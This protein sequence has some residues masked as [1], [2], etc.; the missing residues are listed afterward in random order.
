MN[1]QTVGTQQF[2][3]F[4][5]GAALFIIVPVVI[6]VI[7]KIRKKERFTS[8]LVGAA[9]FFLFAIILEKP[10]QNVLVFPT[11]MGL[12]D[13]SISRFINARPVLWALIIAL[14]PG[15]FEET[16]RFV[17]YKTVLKKYRN[18]ETSISYGIGHGGFEVMFILGMTYIIYLMY[19]VMI[20]TGTFGTVVDQ[21]KAVAPDQVGAMN[22]LASQLAAFSISDLAV[23]TVERI[24]AVLYHVAASILVFYAAR[25]KKKFLLYPLAIILHTFMDG[26]M[27]LNMAGVIT[28][29]PWGLE[30]VCGIFG[31]VTFLGAYCLLYRKDSF[32]AENNQPEN[33]LRENN[34]A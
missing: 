25:D 6:A 5:S 21:L 15:V 22:T 34:Q 20:N 13:H 16:G 28:L 9:A 3:L 19:A 26:I 18:R 27:G 1:Y 17:A 11:A 31:I 24:F 30:L 10:I 2:A 12:P 29:S 7:W 8:I 4:L 23:A 14:F 32:R 33:T